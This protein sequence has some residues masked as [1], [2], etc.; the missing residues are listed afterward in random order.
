MKKVKSKDGENQVVEEFDTF[1]PICMANITGMEEV[2]GDR[3]ISI[4]LEKSSNKKITRKIE[5]FKE[6]RLYTKI[7]DLIRKSVEK[8]IVYSARN[9]H[10]EWND[11]LDTT[12]T[13]LLYTTTLPTYNYTTIHLELFKKIDATGIDGRNLELSFPLIF[14]ADKVGVLDEFIEIIKKVVSEKRENEF[15]EGRDVIVYS[16]IAK[17]EPNTWYRVKDLESNFKQDISYDQNEDKWLNT[18]WFGRALKRLNLI[19]YKRR[20][21][22]GIE[23]MLNIDKAREKLQI[24]K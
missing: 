22:V 13:T 15:M 8:C 9:T 16:L 1:R 20:V 7:M 19:T 18:I 10:Q 2:L 24:F 14:I 11:Y 5:N 3:C 6:N 23:V 4:V 17:Q 21:G 12:D